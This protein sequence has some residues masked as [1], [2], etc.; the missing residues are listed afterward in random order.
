MKLLKAILEGD[1]GIEHFNI[2]A[3]NAG[4]KPHLVL[5]GTRTEILPVSID[6]AKFDLGFNFSESSTAFCVWPSRASQKART[7]GLSMQP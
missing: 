2:L 5:A 4:A 6:A 3:F 1:G 7:N